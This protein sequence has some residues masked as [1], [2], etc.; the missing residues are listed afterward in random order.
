MSAEI[1]GRLIQIKDYACATYPKSFQTYIR[2]LESKTGQKLDSAA[3]EAV[4][5]RMINPSEQP[6][7][8][9]QETTFIA[10]K[11]AK[12]LAPLFLNMKWSILRANQGFFITSDNPVVKEVDPRTRCSFRGD[13]GFLNETAEVTFPLSREFLLLMSWTTAARKKELDRRES[14]GQTKLGLRIQ[15][16]ISMRIFGVR[17]YRLSQFDSKIHG[18][19]GPRKGLGLTNL[20]R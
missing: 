8:L 17:N 20:R 10:M 4:K 13:G 7:V 3:R 16:V 5:Q 15:I 14:M 1:Y 11:S 9:P 18:Q 6:L 19:I 12:E 2:D